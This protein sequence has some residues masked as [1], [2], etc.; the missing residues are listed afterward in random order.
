MRGD[1]RSFT[2]ERPAKLAEALALL[3]G[4][5]RPL[6]IAG[7]TDLYVGLNDG[8]PR[9]SRYLDLSLLSKELRGVEL[10]K[11]GLRIGALTTYTDLR[12][13]REV[14]RFAPVLADVARDVGAIA[15]QNRGTI[16]GSL[17]NASPASDPAPVLM[18]LDGHVEAAS[19]NGKRTI[20]MSDLFTGYR[21]TA[22]EPGELITAVL[23]PRSSVEGWKTW[24]RKVGTRRAQAIS[25]VVVCGAL[26]LGK[27]KPGRSRP[28]G[29]PGAKPLETRVEGVRIA[30]GSLAA[31][32]VR[33]RAVEAALLGAPLDVKTIVRAQDAL[34]RDVTPID[35]VRSTADYRMQVA[36]N[37]LGAMLS[38][39][40]R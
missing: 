35:D 34:S 20:A 6:P 11:A 29:G 23:V 36:R 1:L 30:W 4:A 9:A 5:E 24:Y 14:K 18:A 27:R 10:S 37:L 22:L 38:S 19:A 32:T 26:L 7:G 33:S 28:G 40:A 31:T 13:S 15:I 39:H 21:K 16:G 8:K 12:R 17:G 25:K 2:V 3:A